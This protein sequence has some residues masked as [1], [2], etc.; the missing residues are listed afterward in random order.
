MSR[1]PTMQLP[2]FRYWE[3]LLFPRVDHHIND[4]RNGENQ[5]IIGARS[6]VYAVGIGYPEPF[7]RDFCYPVA[8]L[9]NLIFVIQDIA[10]YLHVL[11]QAERLAINKKDALAL[12]IFNPVIITKRYELLPHAITSA[13]TT[14]SPHWPWRSWLLWF[15]STSVSSS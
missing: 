14:S 6:D 5:D 3:T 1:S 12:G 13:A 4:H 15:F 2:D 10:F 9:V 8:S 7:L 11:T